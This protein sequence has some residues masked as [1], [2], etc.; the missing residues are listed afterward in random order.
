MHQ[1]AG[2]SGVAT[3]DS[4]HSPF[5]SFPVELAAAID[6]FTATSVR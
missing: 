1:A 5:F 6:R 3:L 2:M 4:D